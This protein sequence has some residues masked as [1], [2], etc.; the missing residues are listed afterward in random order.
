MNKLGMQKEINKLY[1]PKNAFG[2]TEL[3]SKLQIMANIEE[4]EKLRNACTICDPNGMVTEVCEE[5][6]GSGEIGVECEH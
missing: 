4:E 1:S 2:N 6:G 3:L 5:C